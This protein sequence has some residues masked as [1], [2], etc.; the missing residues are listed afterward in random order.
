MNKKNWLRS[1]ALYIVVAFYF[2]WGFT[3]LGY[4]SAW[5]GFFYPEDHYFENIGAAS[6]LLAAFIMFF[7]FARAWKVRK[8]LGI[9]SLKLL[10]YFG[11]AFLFFFG[12]GEE[13]SWG[14][15]IFDI[16]EPASLAEAN[17][18]GELNIHNL[19]PFQNNKLLQ[20]ETFFNVFLLVFTVAL[21][22]GSLINKRFHDFVDIY[23]PVVFWGLGI[24]FI[25]D[26]IGAKLA[27]MIYASTYDYII[28][29]AQAVQEVKESNYEFLF[30]FVALWVLHDL[31][32][33]IIKK[34]E[35][36]KNEFKAMSS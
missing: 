10:V 2:L 5:G 34:D 33:Q 27:K 29:F 11:L 22:F 28:P 3:T 17:V 35:A 13:I 30:V 4:G 6:L 9:H 12:G 7:V 25:V 1:P 26:Y 31:N 36:H 16:A 18:Q 32:Q 19:E 21:P 20:F 15:R 24:L 23:T 14:Q 8:V